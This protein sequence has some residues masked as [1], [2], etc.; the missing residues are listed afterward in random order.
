[1]CNQQIVRENAKAFSTKA[2][3]VQ[4]KQKPVACCTTHA[5]E[6]QLKL[7]HIGCLKKKQYPVSYKDIPENLIINH[8]K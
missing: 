3:G 4:I 5:P 6:P 8:L 1:M 7:F 2:A